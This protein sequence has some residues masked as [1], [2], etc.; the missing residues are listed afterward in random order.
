[1]KIY[2]DAENVSSKNYQEIIRLA[3]HYG[4]VDEVRVY[5]IQKDPYTK[6]WS[7]VEKSEK[8]V[9][10]IR[11]YGGHSKNKVDKKIIKDLKK[12]VGMYKTDAFVVVTSDG[13]YAESI[14]ILSEKNT[15]IV[16]GEKKAPEKLRNS[17]NVFKEIGKKKNDRRKK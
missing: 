13:D 8:R 7:E 4:T 14:K 2:I 9:K 11:L 17:G 3:R 16:F 10:S 12:D 1:M 6:G 5:S 15:A